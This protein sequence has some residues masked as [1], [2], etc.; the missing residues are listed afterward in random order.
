MV[1]RNGVPVCDAIQV[2]LDVSAHPSR[3]LEQADLI[4]RKVL[5]PIVEDSGHEPIVTRDTDIVFSATAPF[6]GDIKA[7]L[8]KARVST[9][10][11]SRH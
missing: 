2:W 11:F 6:N 4:Y 8:L 5:R 10:S 9:W 1:N 3:G 7:A